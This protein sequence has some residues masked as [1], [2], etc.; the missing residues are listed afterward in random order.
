MSGVE[1]MDAEKAMIVYQFPCLSNNYA[2]LLHDPASGATAVV[3]TPEV[4]PIEAALA[5]K[6]RE[7]LRKPG[8]SDSSIVLATSKGAKK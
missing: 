2:F 6:G 7:G 3:D 5:L 1:T 4:A 8:L